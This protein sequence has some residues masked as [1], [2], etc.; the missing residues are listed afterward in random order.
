MV[1]NL[2]F[3]W[4]YINA[5]ELL[6]KNVPN[7]HNINIMYRGWNIAA[8]VYESTNEKVQPKLAQ[9]WYTRLKPPSRHNTSVPCRSNAGPASTTLAQDQINTGPTHWAGRGGSNSNPKKAPIRMITVTFQGIV[10]S[11]WKITVDLNSPWTWC[12]LWRE[13]W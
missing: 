9:G 12:T 1:L 10:N 11:L 7:T 6:L 3:Y 4:H 5:S 8:C 2:L 13:K